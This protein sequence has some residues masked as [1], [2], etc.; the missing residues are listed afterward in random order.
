MY[1]LKT[2]DIMYIE[3]SVRPW[4]MIIDPILSSMKTVPGELEK[5]IEELETAYKE[6]LFEFY[7]NKKTEDETLYTNEIQKAFEQE[8]EKKH[9]E[10]YDMD[11]L[12][13]SCSEEDLKNA[14][15]AIAEAKKCFQG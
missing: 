3:D 9:P 13:A 2:G 1:E 6:E 14:A 10:F 15:D 12:L 11:K 4:R 7:R 8:W 5:K